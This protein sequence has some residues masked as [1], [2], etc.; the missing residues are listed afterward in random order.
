MSS[1]PA[2]QIVTVGETRDY[3]W[4]P[5]EK[6]DYTMRLREENIEFVKMILRVN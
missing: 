5:R 2:R 6:G 1:L 4:R 3:E